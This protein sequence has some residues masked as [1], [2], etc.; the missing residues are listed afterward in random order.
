MAQATSRTILS[1]NA[2]VYY[3]GWIACVI[4]ASSG[5]WITGAAVAISPVL[6]HH[7]M[8]TERN[9]RG[10]SRRCRRRRRYRDPHW[11]RANYAGLLVFHVGQP[12]DWLAP[13]WMTVLW[14]LFAITLRYAPWWLNN[15][16]LAAAD[17]GDIGCRRLPPDHGA[18][19]G[20]SRHSWGGSYPIPSTA[21]P[22]VIASSP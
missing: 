2:A 21:F 4:G 12:T 15:R 20:C 13:F 14:M 11:W 18:Q 3:A 17:F 5:H 16:P 6:I 1:L 7:A 8:A 10:T 22:A 19:P 9:V